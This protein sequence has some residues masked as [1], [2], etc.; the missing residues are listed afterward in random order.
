MLKSIQHFMLFGIATLCTYSVLAQPINNDVC[1]AITL[2]V[3]SDCSEYDYTI[4]FADGQSGEPNCTS[5]ENNSVW[6]KFVAPQSSR[7]RVSAKSPGGTLAGTSTLIGV[8]AVEDCSD[9]NTFTQL[10]CEFGTTTNLD[11][12]LGDT[13]YIQV[14]GSS[15]NV[16]AFCIEV[17]SCSVPVN[18]DACDA[19]TLSVNEACTS[20]TFSNVC[21]TSQTSE[22]NCISSENNSVWFKFVAPSSGGV[23]VSA[24]SFG[25]TLS[26]TSTQIGVYTVGDCSD[27]NTYSQLDCDLGATTYLQVTPG[28]T[29]YV[30]VDGFIE[31]VGTFCIEV[32]ECSIP[33][34]DDAC[35]AL[36]LSVDE[37]CTSYAFTNVCATGQAD[38]PNCT[39]VENNSVWFKFVAP[40]S[41]SIRVSAKSPGG[42]LVS[43]LTQM[44]LY[45][46]T[47]CSDFNTYSQL[48]CDSGAITNLN[49]TPGDTYYIQVDGSSANA[50]T[51]CIQVSESDPPT[52]TL[53]SNDAICDA[54]PLT[55]GESCT[56][57]S[58]ECA[59]MENNEPVPAC[60]SNISNQGFNSVWFTFVAPPS[61]RVNIRDKSLLGTQIAIYSVTDCNDFST[62]TE[63]F[64]SS[65]EVNFVDALI[66]GNTYYIQVD[67]WQDAMGEICLEVEACESIPSNDDICNAMPLVLGQNCTITTT[68]CATRELNEPDPSCFV[69]I[70]DQQF[71]SVWFTFTAPTSGSVN[72]IERGVLN[73]RIAI[74]I[75]SNC[76]DF[77]TAEELFCSGLQTNFVN[78]LIPGNTYYLQVDGVTGSVGELC[79]AIE[80][81]APSPT[82]DDICNAIPIIIGEGCVFT[83]NECTTLESNE[84]QPSC[85]IT[86]N[87]DQYF[88]SIWFTFVAPPSG[89]I[90]IRQLGLLNTQM[91]I[92]S[93]PNCSDY[94][95]AVEV[96]C[97]IAETNFVEG[98]VPG[99]MYYIQ[100]DGSL[101]D[102]G[103]I[104]LEIEDPNNICL[105]PE[106]RYL[107]GTETG[108]ISYQ[109]EEQISSSQELTST[110]AVE[111]L[112]GNT[113]TLTTGFSA[114]GE[115]LAKIV[116]CTVNKNEP[117]T[118]EVQPSN[119]EYGLLS[120][121]KKLPITSTRDFDL[122]MFPNP[123]AKE[124]TIAYYLPSA[125]LVT[126][127]LFNSEGEMVRTII[128][129]VY[130]Q[131]GYYQEH[132]NINSF[133]AGFY[134][135]RIVNNGTTVTE[136]VIVTKN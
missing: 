102:V 132:L 95:T 64:C 22:P 105:E 57:T 76:N 35:D 72:I 44:G 51:F 117:N 121:G 110:S 18:D 75:V 27:F 34:N 5:G 38:E 104:C 59:T 97:S 47:D 88:N 58:N 136:K 65:N 10:D 83:T 12:T 52:S 49:V 73:A 53:C 40:P 127:M 84:P 100:V 24:K 107:T 33:V 29:Y 30:Q 32:N 113:V 81:C 124:L 92:Y 134:F 126:L 8:Y 39:S 118:I 135:L 85:F 46:V 48:D 82:N 77:N 109:A 15:T 78:G 55:L 7:V 125:S 93:V 87:K 103:E 62:A 54:I 31:D 90:N 4:A 1:N 3:D 133:P 99:N 68:A 108:V 67:G 66:P 122:K 2:I 106:E 60:F 25:G 79:L 123:A 42:T 43:G 28:E 119:T 101:D 50:G 128:E 71:N 21:A 63:V 6:F 26:A 131:Q 70:S 13:Y 36:T 91:A 9:F 14:D 61:G 16:G 96:F 89:K 56:F 69:N 120:Q 17:E 86:G 23:Q 19:L 45:A 41:G 74:Y 129:N 98:L 20:Y 130:K 11:V 114:L 112:A 37:A 116:S 115:F 111:Y 80:E 94:G